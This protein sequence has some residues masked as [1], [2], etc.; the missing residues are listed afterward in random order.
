MNETQEKIAVI[1]YKGRYNITLDEGYLLKYKILER[2]TGMTRVLL[3]PEMIDMRNNGFVE[4]SV[5][6]DFEDYRPSGSGY[7]LTQK[8]VD[9]VLGK[10]PDLKSD[11]YEY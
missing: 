9:F 8:G 5:A 4:L 10:H 3:K 11:E 1:M 2:E 7:G 6:V